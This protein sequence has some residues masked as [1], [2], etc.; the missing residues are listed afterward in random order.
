MYE[1]LIYVQEL[2]YLIFLNQIHLL[3]TE[4]IHWVWFIHIFIYISSRYVFKETFEALLKMLHL[5]A[6]ESF[7]FHKQTKSEPW[8]STD[9]KMKSKCG[10][11]K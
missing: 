9:G 6:W 7:V 3:M 5:L 2:F 4:L 11:V 10:D 1:F 8:K